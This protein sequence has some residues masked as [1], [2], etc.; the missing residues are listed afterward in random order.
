MSYSPTKYID[1]FD[2]FIIIIFFLSL[3]LSCH[4][5]FLPGNS[6]EPTVIPIAQAQV[7]HCST[8][9]IMCDVPSIAVF[10]SESIQCF[11]G[12][13]S[14]FFL[15]L[16]VTIPVDPIITGIIVHFNL[17]VILNIWFLWRGVVSTLYIST[18]GG[19]LWVR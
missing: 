17:W 2:L 14:K 7:S 3:S 11:P 13:A 19:H 8:F 5:P 15:K 16:L 1:S 18:G 6:L 12:T 9:R 4:R 10:C